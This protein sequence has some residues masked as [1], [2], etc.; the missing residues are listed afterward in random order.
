MKITLYPMFVLVVIASV[1]AIILSIYPGVLTDAIMYA[2]IPA[3]LTAPFIAVIVLGTLI[4]WAWQGKFRTIRIGWKRVAVLLVII[5]S[6]YILLKYYIPR[7]T[8]F[9]LSRSSFEQLFPEAKISKYQGTKL[10][11]RLGIYHVDEYAA[12]ARGGVYFRVHWGPDGIGPDTMSYGF[13]YK[14]NQKGTPF[15][16]A[17]YGLYGLGNDWYW[18]HASND[19]Y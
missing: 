3:F 11:Q 13:V 15:G 14:P 5:F 2:M 19:W 1:T 18:F 7:R 8:A 9:A 16:A 6:T 17:R 12:D 10:N 4:A